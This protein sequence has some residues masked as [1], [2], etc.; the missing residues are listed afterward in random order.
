MIVCHVVRGLLRVLVLPAHFR[1]HEHFT[2][3]RV[4]LELMK[5]FLYR[6]A[7]VSKLAFFDRFLLLDDLE[8]VSLLVEVECQIFVREGGYSLVG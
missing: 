4:V 6:L 2:R 3:Q 8:E 5:N 7:L 1:F